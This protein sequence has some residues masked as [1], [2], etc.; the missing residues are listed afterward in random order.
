MT[1]Y[2]NGEL[3][4]KFITQQKMT[5]PPKNSTMQESAEYFSVYTNIYGQGGKKY[6]QKIYFNKT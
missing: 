6:K 3:R 4:R 1:C 2:R 5:S